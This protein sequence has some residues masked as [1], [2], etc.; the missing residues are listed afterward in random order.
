MNERDRQARA[1]GS[2]AGHQPGRAAARAGRGRLARRR[3]GLLLLRHARRA[4][5]RRSSARS[6]CRPPSPGRGWRWRSALGLAVAAATW[7][8]FAAL[9]R[10]SR[11]RAARFGALEGEADLAPVLRRADAHPDAPPRRPIFAGSDLGTPLDLIDPL[12]ADWTEPRIRPP[13]CRADEYAEFEA[14]RAA[15][16]PE[17]SP[18][19]RARSPPSLRRC[20]SIRPQRSGRRRARR[21]GADARRDDGP[22]GNRPRAQVARA[23]RCRSERHRAQA[24]D[25]PDRRHA[26]RGGRRVAGADRRPPVIAAHRRARSAILHRQRLDRQRHALAADRPRGDDDVGDEMA[27]QGEFGCADRLGQRIGARRLGRL[28][29]RSGAARRQRWRWPTPRY[30]RCGDRAAGRRRRAARAAAGSGRRAS[31]AP[32]SGRRYRPSTRDTV[33]RRGS[34]PLRRSSTK[35]GSRTASRPKRVGATLRARRYFSMTGS[36]CIS[37]PC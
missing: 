19:P 31:G 3:L 2:P 26:A 14:I 37:V 24:R 1:F 32:R 13:P 10:A 29:R 4:G 15:I 30:A 7:F 28:R 35:R 16:S 25:P 22:A 17:P 33:R 9:D 8:G 23:G 11:P 20:E 36:S 5:L 12:P 27:G 34:R 18:A 6:A 21:A